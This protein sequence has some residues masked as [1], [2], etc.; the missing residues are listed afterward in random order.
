MIVNYN[1][2]LFEGIDNT[3]LDIGDIII[4]LDNDDNWGIVYNILR[5]FNPSY[6]YVYNFRNKKPEGTSFWHDK[7]CGNDKYEI[8]SVG[9]FLSRYPERYRNIISFY[10]F[11][12]SSKSHDV[13]IEQIRK[14]WDRDNGF[15]LY[16]DMEKYNL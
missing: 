10:N 5:Q 3:C 6:I 9:E 12:Y 11:K 13:E 14:K 16:L 4:N 15:L 1:S 7:I 2:F 8:L